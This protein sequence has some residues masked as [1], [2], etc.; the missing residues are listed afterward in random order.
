MLI[1][2]LVAALPAEAQPS[3]RFPDSVQIESDGE[4]FRAF[5]LGGFSELLRMDADLALAEAL[6]ANLGGQLLEA[7][8]VI[9][10]LTEALAAT[11]AQVDTLQLERERL[12]AMWTEENR[13]RLQCEESPNAASWVGWGLA[14]AFAVATL[15]LGIVQVIDEG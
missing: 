9:E 13:L 2:T 15:V 12:L 8:A 10:S 14:A 4:T 3:D 5:D 1:A 6:V 11:E 7:R